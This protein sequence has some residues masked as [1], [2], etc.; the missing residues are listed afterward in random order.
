MGP[1]NGNHW[2]V[3]KAQ[4]KRRGN[5]LLV[6]VDLEDLEYFRTVLRSW[7][8]EVVACASYQEALRCLGTDRFDFVLVCQ[9]SCAFE[10][11]C[12]LER[13]I[14]IDQHTPVLVVTRCLEMRCYLEAMQLGALDY[15]EKPAP[16]E[17]IVWLLETDLR[18][19]EKAA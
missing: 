9:W 5:V 14:E 11:R 7:G 17:Q 13:A 1:E 3:P 15:L 19:R 6:D 18:R 16:A 10:G 4:D 2:L 12:V 8:C